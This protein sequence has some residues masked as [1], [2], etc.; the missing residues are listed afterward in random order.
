MKTGHKYLCALFESTAACSSRRV[1]LRSSDGSC[2]CAPGAAAL[3]GL[4]DVDRFVA[5]GA[6]NGDECVE[7]EENRL[8]GVK[9]GAFEFEMAVV[10]WFDGGAVVVVLVL[11]EGESGAVLSS[12]GREF[13]GVEE[14][15]DDAGL[16]SAMSYAA[17]GNGDR[18]AIVLGV[19]ARI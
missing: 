5:A 2:A 9:D 16:W 6:V 12:D 3:V 10:L 17:M 18:K 15:G 1:V 11:D 7:D 13:H 8:L 14:W 19:D 4:L